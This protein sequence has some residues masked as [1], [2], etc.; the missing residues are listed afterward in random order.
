MRAICRT[1][2]AVALAA[3]WV[4]TVAAQQPEPPV[5]DPTPPST[6]DSPRDEPPGDRPVSTS[7]RQD[8]QE[9]VDRFR[10]LDELPP[11]DR[12]PAAPLL[13]TAYAFVMLALFGYLLSVAKR[14][15]VVQ[16]EVERLERDLKKS[17]RG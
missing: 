13:V 7:L 14:L 12:L 10:P 4:T 11:E 9:P 6:F 1:V 5:S 17:G 15:G 3:V 2:I 16:R 8:A